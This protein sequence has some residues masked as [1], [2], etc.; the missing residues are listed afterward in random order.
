M[1]VALV[2]SY[3]QIRQVLLKDLYGQTQMETQ[4]PFSLV[5]H[6]ALL[7]IGRKDREISTGSVLLT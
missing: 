4:F 6:K 3:R 1:L 2:V 7:K 5:L